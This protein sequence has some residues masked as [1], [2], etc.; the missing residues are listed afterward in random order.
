MCSA[1][2]EQRC[3]VNECW[4]DGWGCVFLEMYPPLSIFIL[5]QAAAICTLLAL[6]GYYVS[7]NEREE[8]VPAAFL[9]WAFRPFSVPLNRIFL[10]N[11]FSNLIWN[12]VLFGDVW[13]ISPNSQFMTIKQLQ[14]TSPPIGS[15]GLGWISWVPANGTRPVRGRPHTHTHAHIRGPR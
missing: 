2:A 12:L 1:V 4:V 13:W 11:R 3:C 14:H 8:E 15:L 6:V 10:I 5:K 7:G 9:Q